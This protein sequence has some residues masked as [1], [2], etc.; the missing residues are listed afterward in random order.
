[1]EENT[2]RSNEKE[3]SGI[4]LAGLIL[5][6][7]A[8][9]C[10]TM[11][12]WRSIGMVIGFVALIVSSYSLYRTNKTHEKKIRSVSGIIMSILA[13]LIAAYFLYLRHGDRPES[14]VPVELKD[15]A[16]HE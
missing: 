7:V 5:S 8:L 3:S 9:I 1:M 4:A 13:V 6:I 14:S 2:T 10:A 16:R 12:H 11:S 15:T